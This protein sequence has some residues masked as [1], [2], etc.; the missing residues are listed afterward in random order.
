M[1][2]KLFH[3]PKDDA[4]NNSF[5]FNWCLKRLSTQLKKTTNQNSKIFPK[6]V[7]ATNNNFI[8]KFW[9]LVY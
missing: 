2:G 4:Q 9:G 8:I 5:N 3:I 7:E 1:A 6:V